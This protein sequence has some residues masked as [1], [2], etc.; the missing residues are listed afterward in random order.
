M[1]NATNTPVPP[2]NPMVSRALTWIDDRLRDPMSDQPIGLMFQLDDLS[3]TLY[4]S[5][6]GDFLSTAYYARAL[7][8]AL[9]GWG[10]KA[11]FAVAHASACYGCADHP[12][13][14][15]VNNAHC[16]VLPARELLEGIRQTLIASTSG[17]GRVNGKTRDYRFRIGKRVS[18]QLLAT[19]EIPASASAS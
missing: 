17:S 16:V 6:G 1:N 10:L 14:W 4:W 15:V 18:Y 8:Y 9:D 7:D 5:F 3:S 13:A 12:S 19:H 11:L 2:I